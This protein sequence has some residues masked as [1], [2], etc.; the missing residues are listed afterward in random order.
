MIN[1][2]FLARSRETFQQLRGSMLIENQIN[3]RLKP[4]YKGKNYSLVN[5][6]VMHRHCDK[7]VFNV[8][9]VCKKSNLKNRNMQ[10]LNM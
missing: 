9:I 3:H 5:S 1:I 8:S 10:L 7:H 4:C 2:S 6:D